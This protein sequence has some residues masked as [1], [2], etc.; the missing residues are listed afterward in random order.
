MRLDDSVWRVGCS[1]SSMDK[2][3]EEQEAKA[4]QTRLGRC[5]RG[6]DIV[7]DEQTRSRPRAG[8][9]TR[10]GE[11]KP[12]TVPLNGER[13]TGPGFGTGKTPK[14]GPR[15]HAHTHSLGQAGEKSL[16]N[17][18]ASLRAGP[19]AKGGRLGLPGPATAITGGPLGIHLLAWTRQP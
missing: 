1:S 7:N 15:G 19:R 17:V 4:D 5:W 6:T 16:G 2:E 9:R 3:E 12:L 11:Q 10:P 14:K 8:L 18:P 13:K